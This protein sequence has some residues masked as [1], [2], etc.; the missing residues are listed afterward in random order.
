MAWRHAILW[1][2]LSTALSGACSGTVDL[3]RLGAACARCVPSWGSYDEDLKSGIGPSETAT[4]AGRPLR[5]ECRDGRL[6]LTMHIEGPWASYPA[7]APV[8]IRDPQGQ[9]YRHERVDGAG[10]ERTYRYRI[11][12]ADGRPWLWFSV[13]YPMH[14]ERCML[15]ADGRWP[16]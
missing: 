4:W 3:E 11:A 13:R 14:E 6:D 9:V 12:G 2:L 7:A 1:G 16:E 8:L 15:T 10:S 5:A